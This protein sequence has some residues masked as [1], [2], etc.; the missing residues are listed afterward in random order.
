MTKIKILS[1]NELVENAETIARTTL[2][3]RDNIIFDFEAD[4]KKFSKKL[5]TKLLLKNDNNYKD[6]VKNAIMGIIIQRYL[7][8]IINLGKKKSK[9]FKK[10]YLDK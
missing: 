5:D 9:L 8:D 1:D 2:E 6:A 10:L 4:M 3:Y 7:V